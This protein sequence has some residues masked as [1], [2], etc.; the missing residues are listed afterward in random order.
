MQRG[1]E[2]PGERGASRPAAR[3]RGTVRAVQLLEQLH[4]TGRPTRVGDL[5]RALGAPRSSTYELVGLLTEAGLLET[6]SPEGEVFFGPTLYVYGLDYL[7]EHDL[8]RRGQAEV[9]RLSA[10]TGETAQLCTRAGA[11]YT[12]LHM[13]AS[14]RPFRISSDVGTQIPLPWTA[15]GRLLLAHLPEAE[16]RALL[17]PDDLC[18]PHGPP[19]VLDAFLAAVA[20]AGRDGW[21]ITS[22]L[23]DVLTH[24]IAA[25]VRDARGVTAATLCFVV[26]MDTP[27]GRLESLRDT[28][29]AACRE[30]SPGGRGG[31]RPAG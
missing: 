4:R 7:R 25:P 23:V 6:V 14:R 5:A 15:S 3:E 29:V 20:R 26:P 8:V 2:E 31:I 22:G 24:C 16:I 30:L 18:P 10:E 17:E 1:T 19:I 27:P 9:D 11:R 21:C 13:R 28:L 12:V